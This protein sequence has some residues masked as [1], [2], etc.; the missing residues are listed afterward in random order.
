MQK[1]GRRIAIASCSALFVFGPLIMACSTGVV[2]LCLGR[3]LTGLGIGASAVVTPAYLGEMAPRDKRGQIVALY[4]VML[5]VGM[6]MS[7]LVDFIFKA[8]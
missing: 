1:H 3:F 4:E 7:G 6:L 2:G 8:I 5:C